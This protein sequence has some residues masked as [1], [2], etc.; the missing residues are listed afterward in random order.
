MDSISSSSS[1]HVNHRIAN[2]LGSAML[3][4]LMPDHSHTHCVHQGIPG[5]TCIEADFS[6]NSWYSDTVAVSSDSCHYST[7]KV[8]VAFDVRR[9]WILFV[10][11]GSETQ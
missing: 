3:Q 7:K 9:A 4:V 6:R 5:V 1:T 11:Q 2:A 10:G 8:L